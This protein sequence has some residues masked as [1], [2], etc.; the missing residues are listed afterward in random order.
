[1]VQSMDED[2]PFTRVSSP[3]CKKGYHKGGHISPYDISYVQPVQVVPVGE[4]IA[5]VPVNKGYH[6]KAKGHYSPPS[7]GYHPPS[8]GYGA[9]H[10]PSI[11]YGAPHPPSPGYGAPPA[12][13]PPQSSYSA[14]PAP[15][16]A[17]PKASYS[18]AKAHSPSVVHHVHTHQHVYTGGS[19]GGFGKHDSYS[20]GSGVFLDRSSG[21]SSSSVNK[22]GSAL[23]VIPLGSSNSALSSSSSSF[24]SSSDFQRLYREDCQCV[25]R[26][27]CRDHDIVART[28]RNFGSLLDARTRDTDILS[29]A[30]DDSDNDVAASEKQEVVAKKEDDKTE[31]AVR[32]R[33]DTMKFV[34]DRFSS[35]RPLVRSMRSF[36]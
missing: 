2:M 17:P 34:N 36:A 35:S 30:D 6:H 15:S 21:S 5:S 28:S 16:Y 27:Y 1:M 31:T 7:V 8:T 19:V 4:P 12:Y 22:L 25:E 24:S 9:P 23:P 13:H 11:G 26:I 20:S 10:P 18:H 32:T 3:Q 33:R 14:P 29:T